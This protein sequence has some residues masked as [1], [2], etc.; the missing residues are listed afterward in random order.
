[1]FCYSS[2]LEASAPPQHAAP[3]FPGSTAPPQAYASERHFCL[4]CRTDFTDK[5]E[6]MFHVR[7]HFE[8]HAQQTPSQH[9]SGK[10][11]S[12]PATAELIA[13]GLVDPS[14]LCS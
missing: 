3:Y 8:P 12:D 1:M 7:S 14:G 6:F 11:G 4:M 5:A 9:S 13:R 2:H 10:Q